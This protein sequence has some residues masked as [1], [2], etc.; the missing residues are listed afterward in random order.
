MNN[1]MGLIDLRLSAPYPEWFGIFTAVTIFMEL[2]LLVMLISQ[3]LK[4]IKRNRRK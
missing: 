4:M 1:T 3:G 2:I